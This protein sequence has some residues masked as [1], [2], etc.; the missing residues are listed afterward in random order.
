MRSSLVCILTAVAIFAQSENSAV[1]QGSVRDSQGKPVSSATVQ[2]KAANQTLTAPTD[3]EGQFRFRAL[4]STGYTL[5][6]SKTNLGEADFGPFELVQ[7]ET[8]GIDLTLHAA[9]QFFDEPT[10]IVAGVADP[11]LRGGHGS[12]PVLR[13]AETLAKETASLRVGTSPADAA[14]K[15]G[16]PLQA[17]REYQSAAEQDPT[18]SNLFNWGTEL[19][20]HRAADQAVEVFGK[21]NRL[22]PHSTRTLLGLAVALY[23]RGS[24]Q[25]AARRFFE[26]ADLDPSDPA[27]Y[28]F[29]G[30]VSS[31]AIAD[32]D[33]FRER[34]E[35]FA[36]L[37]PENAWANYYYA[38]SL[39]KQW[40]GA[41]DTS[42]L[43]KAQALLEKAVRLDPRLGVAFLQL[44]I[45]YSEQNPLS[46]AI[47]AYQNAILINPAMEEAHYRLAQAYRK[48]GQS[49]KARTE[50]ELYQKLSQQSA[51]ALERERAEIQQFVFELRTR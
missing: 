37:Q 47:S 31:S 45:V 49:A 46:K 8:K 43:A 18:E 38:A 35:R 25:D 7:Q 42:T 39:W 14:E 20:S 51:Q 19:L 26:A 50:I 9:L 34:L 5:H 36:R 30:K 23:S 28:L 11:T 13:S 29:L 22:F 17:A 27:P 4:P 15:Q 41:D 33:G 10:F 48:T 1:V 12:D 40:K 16:K 6:A 3:S 21:G 24:Y 44:G 32:S 2:L